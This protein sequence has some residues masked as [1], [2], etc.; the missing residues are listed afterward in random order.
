MAG[1][2]AVAAGGLAV[3]VIAAGQA[4]AELNRGP[5]AAERSAAAATAL[6]LRWR[7]WPA[8][9][10]FPARLRY[11]PPGQAALRVG[12]SRQTGCAAGLDP[13]A[14]AAAAR[15]GCQAVLRASYT[16]RLQG[17]VWT[18]GVVAFR[19]PGDA[20]S[21]LRTL[22]G[23]QPL[24]SQPQSGQP[25]AAQPQAGAVRHGYLRTLPPL[26]TPTGT[27][28]I[29]G[30][31]GG[32]RALAIPRSAAGLFTDRARQ[33]VTG[34]QQ[35]PYAVLATAGYAD[36]RPARAGLEQRPSI[37]RPAGQ[38]A[39]D[40]LAPLVVPVSVRCQSPAWQC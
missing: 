20:A 36:G 39:G 33:L 18:I 37:F 10:I 40:V 17:I 26:R 31:S 38:L 12:I 28:V 8:G 3:A 1:L 19:E 22:A 7:T 29:S 21:F 16:D 14:G 30:P 4:R 25:Q 6:A 2:G 32:V 11:G 23:S 5:T 13:V 27:L 35:G 24:T 9:Q 34:W 15:R